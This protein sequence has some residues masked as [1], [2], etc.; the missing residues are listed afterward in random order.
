MGLEPVSAAVP[1]AGDAPV[2]PPRHQSCARDAAATA[3][4]SSCGFADTAP[5]MCALAVGKAMG[6]E[7]ADTS[8][9]YIG[10]NGGDWG[11]MFGEMYGPAPAA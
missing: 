11:P 4:S 8:L 3:P 9:Q 7:K 2:L 5:P 1:V 10:W 6:H